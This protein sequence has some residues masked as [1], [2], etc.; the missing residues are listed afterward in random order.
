M[1]GREAGDV[2][3]VFFRCLFL[4]PVSR[5]FGHH[6]GLVLHSSNFSFCVKN[7]HIFT[8]GSCSL[9]LHPLYTNLHLRAQTK[10]ALFVKYP[11]RSKTV[12]NGHVKHLDKMALTLGR[13]VM[14]R[15]RATCRVKRSDFG[16]KLTLPHFPACFRI[17]PSSLSS[18]CREKHV[19]FGA[20][21]HGRAVH[22]L[23]VFPYV[24]S[25]DRY[26][27]AILLVEM[28]QMDMMSWIC[29]QN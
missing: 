22:L 25:R 1:G 18:D 20:M 27:P 29:Y 6:R 24:W 13:V 19:S 10:A 21:V 16:T 7:G 5:S 2:I 14:S 17:I 12:S 8:K 3:P 28:T 11:D 9:R 23:T 15:S 4:L 26:N